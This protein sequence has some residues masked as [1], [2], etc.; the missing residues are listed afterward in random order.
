MAAGM[1]RGTGGLTVRLFGGEL[2][3]P[4]GFT[5]LTGATPPSAELLSGSL[6]AADAEAARGNQ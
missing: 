3:G 2:V 6:K 1:R 4:A 5:S